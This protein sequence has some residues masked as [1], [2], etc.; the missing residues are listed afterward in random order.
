MDWT[1]DRIAGYIPGVMY[2]GCNVSFASL[3]LF[4]PTIIKE[5]GRFTSQQSNGLSA[6]PYLMVFFLIIVTS[7]V[8]DRLRLRGPF[9][10][11]PAVIGFIGFTLLATREDVASRYLGVFFAVCIFISIAI[12]L[13]WVVNTHSNESKRTGGYAIF[14]TVGQ[15]G[16]LVGTN[17]FPANQAPY[18]KKG[19][20]ISAAFC[21]LVAVLSAAF[22][23]L[24]FWENKR[25]DRTTGENETEVE[26]KE[27]EVGFRYIL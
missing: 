13:P 8:S 5:L 19:M 18:Y 14:S 11:G 7:Y 2:F 4:V 24:L 26:R 17:I 1:N 22:S 21:L 25:L 27:Q 9:V 16:P 20:W 12:L 6:P 10:C 23:F 3:P 15:L